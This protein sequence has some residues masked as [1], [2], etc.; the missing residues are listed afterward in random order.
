MG[1]GAAS[2]GLCRSGHRRQDLSLTTVENQLTTSNREMTLHGG[3]KPLKDDS[4]W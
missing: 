2:R 3:G 4:C 1:S